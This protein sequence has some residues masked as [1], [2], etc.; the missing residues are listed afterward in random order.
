MEMTRVPTE[1]PVESWVG[2]SGLELIQI[3]EIDGLDNPEVTIP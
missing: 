3:E 2:P 1:N